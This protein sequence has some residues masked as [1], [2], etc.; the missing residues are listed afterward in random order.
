MVDNKIDKPKQSLTWRLLF[1]PLE[2]EA[3]E[4]ISEK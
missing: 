2:H 1:N 3:E 4:E